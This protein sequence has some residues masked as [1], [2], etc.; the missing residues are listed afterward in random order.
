MDD[1]ILTKAFTGLPTSWL[2]GSISAAGYDPDIVVAS[3]IDDEGY[4]VMVAGEDGKRI[5]DVTTGRIKS[6]RVPWADPEIGR[7]IAAIHAEESKA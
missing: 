5:Y 3:G 2:R 4:D 1:V 6:I 7:I